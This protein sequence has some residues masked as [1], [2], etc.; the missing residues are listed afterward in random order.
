MQRDTSVRAIVGAG[1][2]AAGRC[3]RPPAKRSI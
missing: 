1:F 2:H 3:R